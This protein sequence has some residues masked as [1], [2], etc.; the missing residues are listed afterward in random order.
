VV[1][2]LSAVEKAALVCL[3]VDEVMDVIAG[4]A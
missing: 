2:L 4:C 3:L 1:I